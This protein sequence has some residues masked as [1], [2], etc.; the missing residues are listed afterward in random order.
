MSSQVMK[1]DFFVA[2][3]TSKAVKDT[4]LLWKTR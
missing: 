1:P 2:P 3:A 4:L